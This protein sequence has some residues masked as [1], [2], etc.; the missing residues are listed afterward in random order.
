MVMPVMPQFMGEDGFDLLWRQFRQQRVE[1]DD[2]LGCTESREVRVSVGRATRS[3]HHEQSAGTESA[4]RQQSLD[5]LPQRNVIERREPV[6][7][8][9]M[10][11]G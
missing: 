5:A 4:S 10:K 6:E 2:A 9:A 7:Q 11:V 1:E 3:I 8:G